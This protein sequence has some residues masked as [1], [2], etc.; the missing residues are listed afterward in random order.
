MLEE[1]E[2]AQTFADANEVP[3]VPSSCCDEDVWQWHRQT[4][5]RRPDLEMLE[6]RM[7]GVGGAA[8]K[9]ATK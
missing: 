8:R 7:C 3:R 4:G 6:K 2:L 5:M 9:A 1:K